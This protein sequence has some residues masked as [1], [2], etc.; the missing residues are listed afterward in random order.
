MLSPRYSIVAVLAL[1]ACTTKEAR[2]PDTAA[3]ATATLAGTPA[4]DVS[5][6]RQAIEAAN[7]R[8]DSAVLKGDTATLAGMYSDDA[9]LMMSGSPA[10]RGH[11]AIRA[12]VRLD[13]P[14]AVQASLWIEK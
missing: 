1:A 12:S 8:F 2:R 9:V 14:D 10:A 3:P 5:A 6:V 7:A 4:S 11:E 13:I